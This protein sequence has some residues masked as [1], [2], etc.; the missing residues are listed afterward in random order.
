MF[1]TQSAF[2]SPSSAFPIG[3]PQTPSMKFMSPTSRRQD[4]RASAR[5]SSGEK[6]FDDSESKWN[7]LGASKV[8]PESHR[9]TTLWYSL[10]QL[11]DE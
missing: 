4:N 7:M 11:T 1:L 10:K 3:N 9:K 5:V 6:M 2:R 8:M